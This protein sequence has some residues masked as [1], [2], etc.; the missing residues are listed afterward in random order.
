MNKR[1]IIGGHSQV[2]F[3]QFRVQ[4]KRGRPI[5]RCDSGM[6]RDSF[7]DQTG[8]CPNDPFRYGG[9]TF[10]GGGRVCPGYVKEQTS[11]NLKQE[12]NEVSSCFD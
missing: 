1:L 10:R 5:E 8:A 6:R 11:K 12:L 9:Y 7:I 2:S 3:T 4:R